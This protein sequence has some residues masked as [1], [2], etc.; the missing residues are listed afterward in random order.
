M[1]EIKALYLE[2]SF[3]P[4]VTQE[5]LRAK[6]VVVHCVV[7]FKCSNVTIFEYPV[8]VA[9]D[10]D[11]P[12]HTNLPAGVKNIHN[13]TNVISRQWRAKDIIDP[14]GDGMFTAQCFIV[15][16]GCPCNDVINNKILGQYSSTQFIIEDSKLSSRSVLC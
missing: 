2:P 4:V 15:G 11:V 9:I 10:G 13:A 12:C 6:A 5:Q 16:H 7:D 1:P 14:D 8:G 3:F